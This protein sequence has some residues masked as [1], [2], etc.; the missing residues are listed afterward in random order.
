MRLRGV[1]RGHQLNKLSTIFTWI[2]IMSSPLVNFN[3]KTFPK[4]RL[5]QSSIFF[6]QIFRDAL[7]KTQA[8]ALS[9]ILKAYFKP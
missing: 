1:L 2:E 7:S 9:F 8:L 5:L 4:H 3:F 6:A